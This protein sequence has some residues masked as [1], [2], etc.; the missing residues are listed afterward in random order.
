M[1]DTECV[2]FL[3]WALPQL[4]LRWAGFR[5]VR[6]QACKRIQRR[7]IELELSD[8][9]AYQSYLKTHP[10]EW[11]ILDRYC[12]I[13]ISRFYRDQHI[14]AHLQ[15][16]LLPQLI[17]LSQERGETELVCWSAGCASGEEA[18]TLSILW[19]LAEFSQR[20]HRSRRIIAT[21][22]NA[23]LLERARTGCYQWGSLKDIPSDWLAKSFTKSD[24]FYCIRPEFREGIE[25]KQQDIRTSMP[26]ESFH[27]ILCR[28]LVL[29]YFD[30][31]LQQKVLSPIVKR[32]I[33]GGVLAVGSHESL[34]S[35]FRQ[36]QAIQL[37]L[38]RKEQ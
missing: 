6:K 12:R 36:M 16:E 34:P 30:A 35:N 25:F 14:F 37:G 4:N 26:S 18:Y 19:H 17:Q 8:I 29:T 23:Y 28:N 9:D 10:E 20:F 38:Y 33:P 7:L 13:T 15:Q 3:Q 2:R 11:T 32:L 27:L 1:K 31:N 5:K 21:D 22:A 24:E